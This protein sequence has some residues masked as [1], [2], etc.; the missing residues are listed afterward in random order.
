MKLLL[1][2]FLISLIGLTTSVTVHGIGTDKFI[3]SYFLLVNFISWCTLLEFGFSRTFLRLGMQNTI[4]NYGLLVRL[5]K[6]FR[7]RSALACIILLSVFLQKTQ[8]Y[9]LTQF[10]LLVLIGCASY[11]ANILRSYNEGFDEIERV[12][13]ARSIYQFL[14]LTSAVL[15]VKYNEVMI[16]WYGAFISSVFLLWNMFLIYKNKCNTIK[17]TSLIQPKAE[18]GKSSLSRLLFAYSVIGI[19]LLIFD[20]SFIV[21]LLV[22]NADDYLFYLDTLMKVTAIFAIFSQRFVNKGVF[23]KSGSVLYSR[24]IIFNLA[25]LFV[26]F[27]VSI[28]V[29]SYFIDGQFLNDF[30]YVFMSV[31][32]LCYSVSLTCF[33][34]LLKF[35]CEK[36]YIKYTIIEFI[37]FVII[38]GISGE[39]FLLVIF[40]R[41]V[42]NAIFA[43]GFCYHESNKFNFV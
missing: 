19:V 6:T 7:F 2:I 24:F 39:S 33:I 17:I 38:M 28:L 36:N 12:L 10:I 4:G 22:D 32:Y 31:T 20:K 40:L 29:H 5:S 26:V 27:T 35:D 14:L 21:I 23:I 37:P 15:T 43:L 11:G 3:V 18:L 9:T 25:L 13:T 42:L 8:L 34:I 16:L 1:G 41:A 30:N